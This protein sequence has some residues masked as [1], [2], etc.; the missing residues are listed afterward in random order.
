MNY[1][2]VL[3]TPEYYTTSKEASGGGLRSPGYSSRVSKVRMKDH[4]LSTGMDNVASKQPCLIVQHAWWC[5]G[6]SRIVVYGCVLIFRC[7]GDLWA[8]G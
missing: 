8:C 1:Q 7:V 3:P 2:V 4:V 6:Y 5:G